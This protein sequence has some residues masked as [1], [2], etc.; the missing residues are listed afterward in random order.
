MYDTRKHWVFL[1]CPSGEL[2][3]PLFRFGQAIGNGNSKNVT[4]HADALMKI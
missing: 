4:A 3:L 2:G 1:A